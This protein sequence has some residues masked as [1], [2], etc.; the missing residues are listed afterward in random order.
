MGLSIEF[1]EY[2]RVHKNFMK[3]MDCLEEILVIATKQ[4][5]IEIG[6][7]VEELLKEI[8]KIDQTQNPIV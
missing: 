6:K 1:S 5:N 2:R 7:K 4:N 8:E 3:C